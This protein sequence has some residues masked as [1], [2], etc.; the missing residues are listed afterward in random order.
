MRLTEE[1]LLFLA[2]KLD[3][4]IDAGR[5]SVPDTDP[6][7]IAYMDQLEAAASQLEHGLPSKPDDSVVRS[8]RWARRLMMRTLV[9]WFLGA[10]RVCAHD[11]NY[12][13][14]QPV[15]S[16]SWTPNVVVCAHCV[17]L[18]GS[19]PRT[20]ANCG[21]E[22]VGFLRLKTGAMA[23]AATTCDGCATE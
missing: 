21:A 12:E 20:C 4:D 19:W 2:D 18:L 17:P 7:T 11:P 1:H 15:L 23:F 6:G 8:P 16:C 5:M 14:P 13:Q 22:A 3:A 9:G 10:D